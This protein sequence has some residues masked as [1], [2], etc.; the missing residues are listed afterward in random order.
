[1]FIRKRRQARNRGVRRG[2][3]LAAATLL[4]SL[5]AA[6]ASAAPYQ[7]S[8][9]GASRD[10]PLSTTCVISVS[11][12]VVKSLYASHSRRSLRPVPAPAPYFKITFNAAGGSRKRL[13]M[14]YVPSR[15]LLR[16]LPSKGGSYWRQAP[17]SFR[18]AILG[19]TLRL[20]PFTSPFRWR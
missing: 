12:H 11:E 17:R 1:V 4:L 2:S 6:D 16:V 9:C 13:S 15:R 14:L 18:Q 5:F 7:A 3:A 20:T 10:L 8:V 19:F